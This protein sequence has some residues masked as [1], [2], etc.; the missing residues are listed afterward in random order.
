MRSNGE[1]LSNRS[2]NSSNKHASSRHNQTQ[3]RD[4]QVNDTMKDLLSR[5]ENNKFL[6]DGNYAN[7]QLDETA[8]HPADPLQQIKMAF[9]MA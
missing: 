8:I 4:S 7:S 5:G 1:I 9:P 3:V 6:S 2:K